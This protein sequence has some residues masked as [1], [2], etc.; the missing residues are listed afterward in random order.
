[1]ANNVN[2]GKV[3]CEILGNGAFGDVFY[4]T[5]SIPNNSV[6]TCWTTSVVTDV[7]VSSFL[8][9]SGGYY[10]SSYANQP[11][12]QLSSDAFI[13]TE[14]RV[15]WYNFQ[16]RYSYSVSHSKNYSFTNET[17]LAFNSQLN[18][19]QYNAYPQYLMFYDNIDLDSNDSANIINV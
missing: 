2:W 4:N 19:Y 8:S 3:Y 16:Y 15:N 18:I 11:F 6:P 17:N 5:N 14:W 13:R 7:V 1:M 9:N 10:V 12:S